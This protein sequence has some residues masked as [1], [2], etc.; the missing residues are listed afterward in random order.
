MAGQK[1][2]GTKQRV[3]H[4]TVFFKLRS[5]E[6]SYHLDIYNLSCDLQLT[7][8]IKKLALNS[9]QFDQ[10]IGE[11][12]GT[13]CMPHSSE[14]QYN[15]NYSITGRVSNL[16][17]SAIDSDQIAEPFY[18]TRFG[19]KRLLALQQGQKGWDMF[20]HFFWNH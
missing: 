16:R 19:L 6:T 10:E 8:M 15:V 1:W 7:F 11:M 2:G 18:E 4:L 12:G 9:L 14:N 20:F 3:G 13:N 17:F 5:S